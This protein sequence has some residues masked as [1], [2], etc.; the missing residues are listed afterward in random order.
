MFFLIIFVFILLVLY[1][2]KEMKRPQNF[3]PG[4]MWLPFIGNLHELKKLSKFLGGQHHALQELAHKYN[5]NVLGLKL[6][7]EYIVTVFTYPLIREVLT[8][9]EYQGRP[10]N[11]FLRLRC[12][13]K[14]N[15]IT[16]TDG[17]MWSN[18]RNFVNRHLRNLG[19]GKKQ[20]EEMIREE[21]VEVLNILYTDGGDINVDKFLAPSV[22]NVIWALITDLF[23]RRSKAFDMTGGTLSLYPWLRYILPEWSGYNLIQRVNANMK[24]FF[25]KTIYEHQQSWKEG[26]NDDLIYRYISEMRAN[27]NDDEDFIE[28]QLVMICLDLF[29]G[30]AQTTSGT[31]N[32]AFLLMIMY[33]DIQKKVQNEI[34]ENFEKGSII[35]YSERHKVPYV[36]AVLM[37]IM[38]FRHVI[39]VSGPRRVMQ[40]TTLDGYTI[41]KDTTVLISLYSVHNSPEYWNNPEIFEPERFLDEKGCLI[42]NERLLPFGLGKRRCLAE[43]LAKTCIFMFFVEI[44]RKYTVCLAPG[45]EPLTEKYI[46]GI[47]LSPTR[48]QARF[49][50]RTTNI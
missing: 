7:S 43:V 9:E 20:M 33:P 50:A 25:M 32:F 48:Y 39:P 36:E 13:G 26:K 12:M 10:D 17:E 8:S 5:T 37:E 3:P 34:D 4:P 27:N 18:Q 30:G 42:T 24:N 49:V 31:L 45:S 35:D 16:C 38:R 11:F 14:R 46:P 1:V 21:V 22:L 2:I 6:G 44:L 15:G 41:P 40:E 28:E 23:N 19:F 47:I 29:I